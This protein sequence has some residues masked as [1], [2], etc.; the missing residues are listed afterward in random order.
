MWEGVLMDEALLIRNCLVAP[1]TFRVGSL[2]SVSAL[3]ETLGK[4][5]GALSTAKV[6]VWR[7]VG[8]WETFFISVPLN[9]RVISHMLH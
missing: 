9:C 5:L 2:L 8:G 4:L 7:E 1:S 3:N 6:T